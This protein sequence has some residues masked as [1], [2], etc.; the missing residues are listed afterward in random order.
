MLTR[1]SRRIYATRIYSM[2]VGMK[3]GTVT[4]EDTL[5]SFLQNCSLVFTRMSWKLMSIWNLHTDVY[6]SFIH[7]CQNLALTKMSFKGEWINK[8]WYIQTKEYYSL[9]KRNELSSHEKT[10]KKLKRIWLSER[11]Q[12]EKTTS[13]VISTIWHS[14]KRQNYGGSKKI[15]GCQGLEGQ[16]MNQESSEVYRAVNLLCMILWG[17]DGYIPLYICPNP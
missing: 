16:G 13:C 4:L 3:N 5:S 8:Q 2:L 11:S 10:W 15:S 1:I 17:W 14:G 7:N 12:S 9:L 6:H